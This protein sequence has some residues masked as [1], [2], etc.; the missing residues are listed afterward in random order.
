M[1]ECQN[2]HEQLTVYL[3][4]AKCL[5]VTFPPKATVNYKFESLMFGIHR[6]NVSTAC[7]SI[8]RDVHLPND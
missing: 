3:M 1:R 2:S 8:G 6:A 7:L 5:P 4:L